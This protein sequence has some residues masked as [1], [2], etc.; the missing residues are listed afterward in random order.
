MENAQIFL[1]C[2]EKM[3][4]MDMYCTPSCSIE[5][6]D[7]EQFYFT[8]AA[9]ILQLL[10]TGCTD[11]TIIVHGL[12]RLYNHTARTAP[13]RQ[14]VCTGCADCTT[15][16]HGLYIFCNYCTRAVQI[17]QPL[18]TSCTDCSSIAHNSNCQ[19][20]KKVLIFVQIRTWFRAEFKS[21]FR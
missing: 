17:E 15:I 19:N 2:H 1:N 14:L 11:C 9:H 8:E 20:S 21:G 6:E 13:I 7:R 16:V 5:W 12:Y 10:Y 18:Y 4:K 3:M